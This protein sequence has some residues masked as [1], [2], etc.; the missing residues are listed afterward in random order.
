MHQKWII[1]VVFS[2]EYLIWW[3]FSDK[4]IQNTL[5]KS[6]FDTNYFKIY[7][8]KGRNYLPKT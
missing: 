4:I 6:T 2:A 3:C 7:V 8:I 5:Q 1:V